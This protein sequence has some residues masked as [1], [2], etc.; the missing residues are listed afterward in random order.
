GTPPQGAGD[1]RRLKKSRTHLLSDAARPLE[2]VGRGEE[3]ARRCIGAGSSSG[4][5][6]LTP[7]VW[8]LRS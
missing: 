3:I 2:T 1:F 6:G 4:R 8:Y 7:P 5:S